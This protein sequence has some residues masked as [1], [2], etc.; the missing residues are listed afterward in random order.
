LDTDKILEQIKRETDKKIEF[1][2]CGNKT[3]Y[4]GEEINIDNL[5]NEDKSNLFVLIEDIPIGIPILIK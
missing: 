2:T 4:D 1:M 3:V 5:N